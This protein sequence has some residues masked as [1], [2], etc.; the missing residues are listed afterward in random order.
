M[1][2]QKTKFHCNSIEFKNSQDVLNIKKVSK[3]KYL[4][5]M[6]SQKTSD[7]INLAKKNI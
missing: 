6:L 3:L 2:N 1:N 7:I 4:G 5:F